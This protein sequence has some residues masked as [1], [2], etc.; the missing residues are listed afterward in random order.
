MRLR[1]PSKKNEQITLQ[2]GA[3]VRTDGEGRV[4]VADQN[5]AQAL[6]DQGGGWTRDDGAQQQQSTQRQQQRR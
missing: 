5:D 3:T 4:E 6:L 2:S 1:N